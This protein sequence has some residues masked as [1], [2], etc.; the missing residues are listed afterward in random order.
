MVPSPSGWCF[1]YIYSG[2]NEANAFNELQ[3]YWYAQKYSMINVRIEHQ[4][5]KKEVYL[6]NALKITAVVVL[7]VSS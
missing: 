7:D 1:I 4:T 5:S 3:K 6:T 2:A